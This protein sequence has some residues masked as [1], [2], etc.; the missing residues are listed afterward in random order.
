MNEIMKHSYMK[1]FAHEMR[2]RPQRKGTYG[3]LMGLE[4]IQWKYHP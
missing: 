2:N 3:E 1:L 4:L